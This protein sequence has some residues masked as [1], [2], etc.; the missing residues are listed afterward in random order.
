VLLAPAALLYGGVVHV[1][2]RLFDMGIFTSQELP[3]PVI[4]IGNLTVG[5]TGKTPLVATL[6]RHIAERGQRAAILS[7]GYGGSLSGRP[8]V[9]S[10]GNGA[11]GP[12][13]GADVAGD[14][15]VLLSQQLPDVCV[16]VGGNRRETGTIA[17]EQLGADVILLDDGFQHRWLRRDLDILVLDA[18]EPFGRY[19]LLPSGL[20]RE[21]ISSLERANI[22]VVTRSHPD[23]PLQTLQEVVRRH[24]PA[25]PVFR[26]YHRPVCFVPLDGSTVVPLRDLSGIKAAAF[27]GIGNPDAFRADLLELG[28]DIV[29]FEPFRDHHR[30]SG[31][32]IARLFRDAREAGAGCLITTEKDAVRL[33]PGPSGGS[34]GAGTVSGALPIFA[35]RIRCDVHPEAAFFAEVDRI[36]AGREGRG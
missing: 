34:K 14:E 3:I 21:P 17:L 7:R 23:D 20:L 27:C 35:L 16:V 32:E 4:S 18:G 2:N 9:V 8:Y 19:R 5:G 10:N 25:A 30:Y 12:L 1:R 15:P 36:T 33:P 11:S 28:V 29:V 24:N 22:V 6:A 13:T 26:A 31:E